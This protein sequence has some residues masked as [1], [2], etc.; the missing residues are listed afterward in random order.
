V[1]A[2]RGVDAVADGLVHDAQG[3]TLAVE[4]ADHDGE[5]TLAADEVLGAV[6]RIDH[7]DPLAL[8]AAAVVG[9]LFGE[10][11]VV[12]EGGAQAVDDE[13]VGLTVGLGDRLVARLALDGQAALVK[14]TDQRAGSSSQLTGDR[15]LAGVVGQGYA[16]S[17]MA[18]D[19]TTRPSCVLVVTT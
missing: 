7:P 11:A 3:G 17:A 12:G 13:R 6:E 15:E 9:E 14:A 8:K 19:S 16:T 5:A 1:A 18:L 2:R 10:E 4:E